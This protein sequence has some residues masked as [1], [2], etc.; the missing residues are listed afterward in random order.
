MPSPRPLSRACRLLPTSQQRSCPTHARCAPCSSGKQR[1][2]SAPNLPPSCASSTCGLERCRALACPAANHPRASLRLANAAALPGSRPAS[3]PLPHDCGGNRL[4]NFAACCTPSYQ[5][6]VAPGTICPALPQV[7]S[8]LHI[9]VAPDNPDSVAAVILVKARELQGISSTPS[10]EGEEGGAVAAAAARARAGLGASGTGCSGPE[11]GGVE[12]VALA[13]PPG[14]PGNLVGGVII[15]V[16]GRGH[17]RLEVSSKHPVLS[18]P[19]RVAA[20]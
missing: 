2:L 12:A 5:P 9:I 1:R 13:G 19:L 4:I 15:V 10:A 14:D 7:P 18:W 8:D 20:F 3:P 16:A 17:P 11:G 6:F